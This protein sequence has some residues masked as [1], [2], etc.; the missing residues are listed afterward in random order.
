M[1]PISSGA[2]VVRS[3]FYKMR[4]KLAKAGLV[5]RDEAE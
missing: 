4:E 3:R 2:P 1:R 5:H